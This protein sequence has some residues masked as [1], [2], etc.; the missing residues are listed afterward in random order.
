MAVK[1]ISSLNESLMAFMTPENMNEY[2]QV[3]CDSCNKKQDMW[4]G[5]NI[6][7]L[8]NVLVF[9]LNRFDFDYEKMDRVKINDYF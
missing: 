8:P 6:K 5:T 7:I 9:T 4:L 1:N 2:N 3:L